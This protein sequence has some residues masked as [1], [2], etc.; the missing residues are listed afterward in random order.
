M[1]N[2]IEII[3]D[4]G[5]LFS[6]LGDDPNILKLYLLE[7]KGENNKCF[8]DCEIFFHELSKL[9]M[10]TEIIP[11]VQIEEKDEELSNLDDKTRFA[12]EAWKIVNAQ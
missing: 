1:N 5:K 6:F 10:K 12:L 2:T 8:K 4:T 11:K 7:H 3:H 9:H